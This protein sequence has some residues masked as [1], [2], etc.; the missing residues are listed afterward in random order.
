M[1]QVHATILLITLATATGLSQAAEPARNNEPDHHDAL[2]RTLAQIEG[3]L[4]QADD[5]QDDPMF[6]PPG[7]PPRGHRD[8]R[9]R[10]GRPPGRMDDRR[11]PGRFRDRG[12]A[13]RP[14]DEQG[15]RMGRGERGP[16]RGGP[17]EPLSQEQVDKVMALM[18]EHYPDR[19][20]RLTQLKERDPLAFERIVGAFARP[21]M[22]ILEVME[23]DPELGKLMI[24]EHRTRMELVQLGRDYRR[25]QS[26]EEKE[27]LLVQIREKLETRFTLQQQRMQRELD[28]FRKRLEMQAQKL[29][30]RREKKVEIINAEML[31]VQGLLGDE[32]EPPPPPPP[33]QQ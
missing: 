7:P 11:G 25:S 19:Y 32:Q 3:D 21:L 27:K 24:A 1:K 9:G 5:W 14:Y 30:Q 20:T 23:K 28:N 8:M 18:K 22:R 13:S 2:Q 31:R 33:G 17:H 10:R 15:P 16:L 12:P 29:Q 4:G 6:D 26:P